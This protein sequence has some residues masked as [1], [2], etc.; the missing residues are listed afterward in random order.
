[1]GV[2][3]VRVG[4]YGGASERL[5]NDLL[6]RRL[7]LLSQCGG[8][9]LRQCRGF[10]QLALKGS[11]LEVVRD[12]QTAGRLVHTL[13]RHEGEHSI[14][15]DILHIVVGQPP[16]QPAKLLIFETRLALQGGELGRK[17]SNVRLC[18]LQQVLTLLLR[19]SKAADG[20]A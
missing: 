14:E 3:R 6:C 12:H 4:G 17:A 18:L 2:M 13:G 5:L 15:L 19:L 10:V 1:M 9:V 7:P 20:R 8:K 11:L 16:S